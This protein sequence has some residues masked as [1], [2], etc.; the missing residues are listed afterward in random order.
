MNFDL[1]AE[2]THLV[3]CQKVKADRTFYL[4][5]SECEIIYM[6]DLLSSP[7]ET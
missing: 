7:K 2:L 3:N 5:I 4:R 1:S 6:C